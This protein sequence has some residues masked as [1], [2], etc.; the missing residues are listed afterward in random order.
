MS[1]DTGTQRREA[2]FHDKWASSTSLEG[3]LVR[4]SFE[5][6]TAMENHFI[7]RRMGTLADKRLLDIGAGLGE[8]SVY[9]ALHG[10]QVTAGA[11][12]GDRR[13]PAAPSANALG[14][15]GHVFI[16]AV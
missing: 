3:V 6:P 8:S 1:S 7:L 10:A 12:D 15:T 14:R 4:E 13:R 11:G 9:F 5:A 16:F 2:A